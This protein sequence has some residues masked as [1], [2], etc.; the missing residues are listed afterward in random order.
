M[1]E[2]RNRI[3]HMLKDGKISVQEAEELLSALEGHSEEMEQV[4]VSSGAGKRLKYIRVVVEPEA[5]DGKKERVNIKVPLSIIRAGVKMTTI[6]P[7]E[8]KKKID[9]AFKEKGLGI[10]MEDLKAENI[11]EFIQALSDMS[12]DVEADDKKVRIFCE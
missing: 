9:S 6:L 3:L 10:S 2:E 12:I 7:E 8:A 1:N 4:S 5:G 11:E